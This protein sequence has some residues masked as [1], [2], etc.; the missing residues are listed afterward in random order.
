MTNDR[1][2]AGLRCKHGGYYNCDD[3]YTPGQL[4][5]HKW[6]KCQTVD[7]FSWCNRR[8]M[9]SSDLMDLPSI[10]KVCVTACETW[11]AISA[12]PGLAS[13]RIQAVQVSA[14]VLVSFYIYN[15]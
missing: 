15:I 11:I 6:E 2:G 3:E 14:I 5:T 13:L 12:A 4:P 7:K 8:N 10:V 1:W 9:K